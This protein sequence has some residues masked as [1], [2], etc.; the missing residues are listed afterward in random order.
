MQARRLTA[1]HA[2]KLWSVFYDAYGSEQMGAS[3]GWKHAPETVPAGKKVYAFG[4]DNDCV[5]WGGIY[6]N[7]N[8]ATDDEAFL[9]V[10]VFPQHQRQGRRAVILEWLANK[11]FSLGADQ[12]SIIVYRAN[13]AQYNRT[14]REAHVEDAKWVYAGDVWYPK[15]GYGYFVYS[16]APEQPP[17]PQDVPDGS[18]A[19]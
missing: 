10:G 18:S 6:L 11:A 7:T 15:P 17:V 16:P 14:M 2:V 9:T 3:F 19:V 4:L 1:Q 12:A 5:G 8:D 13:E